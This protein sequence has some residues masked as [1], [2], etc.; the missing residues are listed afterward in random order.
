MKKMIAL[1]L[2]AATAFTVLTGCG[3][4]AAETAPMGEKNEPEVE[5]NEYQEATV[6]MYDWLCDYVNEKTEDACP[7]AKEFVEHYKEIL[8][9]GDVSAHG[10]YYPVPTAVDEAENAISL[11]YDDL[12]VTINKEDLSV[13]VMLLLEDEPSEE[14]SAELLDAMENLYSAAQNFGSGVAQ[15]NEIP[16]VYAQQMYDNGDVLIGMEEHAPI[17]IREYAETQEVYFDYANDVSVKWDKNTDQLTLENTDTEA[18]N[19]Y[20]EKAPR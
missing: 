14:I 6:Q 15:M 2:A 5:L 17:L 11:L 7:V 16:V 10:K 20:Q 9:A 19:A 8:E 3:A 18:R 4:P 13:D 12:M 1:V